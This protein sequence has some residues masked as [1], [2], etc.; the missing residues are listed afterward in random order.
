LS[1]VH[2]SL[3]VSGIHLRTLGKSRTWVHEQL[4]ELVPL[5]K[6]WFDYVSIGAQDASRCP[7]KQLVECVRRA[8]RAGADRVRI[9]D[10]VGIWDPLRTHAIVS[11][12]IP[13][14]EGMDLGFHAHND[15]G[16]AT[17]N[18]IA[19]VQ[20]GAGC[21]DVTVNG[22]GERAGNAALEQ[23]VMAAETSLQQ[24]TGINRRRLTALSRTV[25]E[26][27]NRSLPPDQPIVGENVFRHESGIHVHAM[28]KDERTYQPFSAETVGQ[29]G[30]EYVIGKHSGTSSLRQAL[31]ERNIEL[32]PEQ[33]RQLLARVREQACQRSGGFTIED[34]TALLQPASREAAKGCTRDKPHGDLMQR[35]EKGPCG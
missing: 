11:A 20:A 23:V 31:A 26:T 7:P 13:V 5:A 22:L 1:A 35:A 21:I 6:R 18:A 33:S 29:T 14:A 8:R 24:D 28:L 12:L 30:C 25:A 4:D 32:S 2:L 27:S 17:A 15:L 9:S 16:M 3:P 34:I 10:T 19:A